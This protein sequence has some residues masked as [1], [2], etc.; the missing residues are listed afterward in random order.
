MDE[1]TRLKF[2]AAFDLIAALAEVV[3]KDTQDAEETPEMSDARDYMW[4][5][6]DEANEAKGQWWG[7]G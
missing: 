4:R 2:L 6:A 1:A 5:I 7:N 3:L